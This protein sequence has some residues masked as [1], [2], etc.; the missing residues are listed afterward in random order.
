MDVM[1]AYYLLTEQP[2]ITDSPSQS[3]SRWH[4]C[5]RQTQCGPGTAHDDDI[6]STDPVRRRNC[7]GVDTLPESSGMLPQTLEEAI[8]DDHA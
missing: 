7:E 3:Y 8:A 2:D 5:Q 1:K 4:P 6:P